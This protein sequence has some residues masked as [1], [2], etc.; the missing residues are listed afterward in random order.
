MP[1]LTTEPSPAILSPLK[2]IKAIGLLIFGVVLAADLWSKSYMQDLLGLAAGPDVRVSARSIDVIPGFLAWQ[3]TWNPGV[4]F[5]MFA[6]ETTFILILTGLATCALFVWFLGTKYA[7]KALHVGLSLIIAGAVGNL[8]DRVKWD[9]VRDFILVYLGDLEA[10]TWTWPNFNI[11][12]S[13]I[14][15]GVIL[16]LWDSLFGLG[17]KRA[18]EKDEAR[19]A[20]KAKKAM[21]PDA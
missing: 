17:A 4:T 15:C 13:G 8:Y 21:G 10:P 11:A 14:V 6:G 5:G 16:V 1:S 12:D 19:R 7:G 9:K 18:K 2:R 20:A 3:G